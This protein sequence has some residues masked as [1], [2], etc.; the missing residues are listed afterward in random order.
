MDAIYRQLSQFYIDKT[1]SAL[2]ADLS[3][4]GMK[5]NDAHARRHQALHGHLPPE[6]GPARARYLF[7]HTLQFRLMWSQGENV[8]PIPI[9]IGTS[10]AQTLAAEVDFGD[11]FTQKPH[12]PLSY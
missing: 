2:P 6:N 11:T 10:A 4:V 12:E 8:L 7:P 5:S 3:V 9:A 1:L